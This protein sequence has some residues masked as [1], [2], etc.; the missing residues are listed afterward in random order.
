M[1]TVQRICPNC[2]ASNDSS[3]ARCS[4]CGTSLTNLP[5]PGQSQVPARSQKVEVAGLV[6]SAT[7]IIARVGLRL[8]A[9]QVLPRLRGQ[10]ARPSAMT[11][12]HAPR[13]ADVGPRDSRSPAQDDSPDYVIRGWRAWS[14]RRNEDQSSG[15][16][17]FEWRI[18][19]RRE[20][21]A[22]KD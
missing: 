4:K 7:A 13:Q 1:A 14:V 12:D 5:V 19:R 22:E 10:H 17:S 20:G 16:E 21:G 9:R 18:S 15:S 6:L 8:L 2:G 3:R 11:I